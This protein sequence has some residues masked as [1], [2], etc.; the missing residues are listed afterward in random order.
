MG[1]SKTLNNLR[2]EFLGHL[3]SFRALAILKIV[4]GHAMAAAFIGVYGL[5]DDSKLVLLVS[6]IIYHDSTLYFAIISGL[7]FSKV[8]KQ[9]GYFKFYISKIKHIVLPYLFLTIVLTL[10]KIDFNNFSSFSK[11]LDYT[12]NKVGL[13][14]LYGQASFALWYIPV[15]LCLYL[16][17]PLLSFLQTKNK[18]GNLVFL[19]IIFIP[20]F[21]SRVP[22]SQDYVLRIETVIYFAGAYAFGMFLGE[23]LNQNLFLIDKYKKLLIALAVLSTIYLFYLFW[24]EIK[25]TG[26]VNIKETIFY[27][28]KTCFACL[29]MLFFFKLE[30][31]QPKW[32]HPIARDSFAIYFIHG[33]LLYVLLPL[34]LFN[35]FKNNSVSVVF[36]ALLLFTSSIVISMLIVKIFNKI[37]G[38]YSRMIVGS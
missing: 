2:P 7:L 16:L 8:L 34:F 9:K 13:N 28:Q 31:K 3:H 10:V 19:A 14:M 17:T 15:L 4:F 32:M 35:S 11:I 29:F 12:A 23:N 1:T 38:K 5:F 20:I 36:I 25:S 27:I 33:P 21:I 26:I 6:E 18:M 24:N 22:I 30:D 37:F